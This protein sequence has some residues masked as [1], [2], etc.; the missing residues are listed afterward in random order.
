MAPPASS[1]SP[2]ASASCCGGASSRTPDPHPRSRPGTYTVKGRSITLSFPGKKPITG[3]MT[4]RGV[5][6]F[7]ELG[8]F[9]DSPSE[10]EA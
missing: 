1:P 3:Q 4:P 8:T 5:L 7:E 9:L 10:C 2:M 6:E